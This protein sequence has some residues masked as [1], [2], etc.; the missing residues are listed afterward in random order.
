[1]AKSELLLA[2]NELLE[3]RHL[4]SEAVT[5]VLE[6]AL[7]AAY[8][9]EAGAPSSQNVE[10]EID[11]A[12]G[13][14]SVKAEKEV[15]LEV[16]NPATEISLEEAE[17][18]DPEVQ[19]GD[20]V[21]V[22]VT[23]ERLGRVAAQTARQVL[24]QRLREVE[25]ELQ[26]QYFSKLEG[27]I[28]NGIVQAVRPNGV[29][30]GLE[31]NT[32]ALL[33]RREQIPG[34]R[35]RVHDRVRALLLE[36]KPTG[37]G[38]QV[39]LSRAHKNFLRRLLED[40]V[41]EI[42]RGEVEIRAIAREAGRRSK[43]A[44]SA[45]APT[46]DPVGACVGL[47]GVRIQAIMR[48][49][50]GEKIDVIEWNPDPEVFIA[51]AL[52]PAQVTGVYLDHESRTAT[53]VVP[54]DQLSLAIGRQ[55]QNARLAAKLTGWR[56]D[57]KNVSEA[58]SEALYKLQNDPQY[59]PFAEAEAETIPV[60]EAILAKK[61]EGRLLAPEEYR[62]LSR[63]VDRVER[64]V[65]ARRAEE[66]SE[67][68]R[69]LAE[70][71]AQIPEAAFELPVDVLGLTPRITMLLTNA[72]YN[73]IGDLM[74]QMKLNPDEVL[75][76][77]GIGPKAMEQITETLALFEEAHPTEEPQ[78]EVEEPVAPAEGEPHLGEEEAVAEAE[79][80]APV[81]EAKAEAEA[82][83][84]VAAEVEE[85]VEEA[86][87][88]AEAASEAAEEAEE[89]EES[90]S[91]EDIFAQVEI[92]ADEVAVDEEAEEEELAADK[93]RKKKKKKKKKKPRQYVELAYGESEDDL[94]PV[95][96][97]KREDE[98]EEWDF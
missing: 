71:R 89:V 22:D 98:W 82:E 16:E 79:A 56:I 25:R 91:L 87:P 38:P 2:F 70:A 3:E 34:E 4:P 49:L 88:E 68:A 86:T 73:S 61:A 60:V 74:L 50:H 97:H 66:L 27:E 95:K 42:Y 21:M 52:S 1:M 12:D 59:A 96:R 76:L 75:A 13:H 14:F 17:Q 45:I 15:V 84:Q 67:E 81:E 51:K 94:I 72:G 57:I 5:S 31:K 8:R 28:V 64:G 47:R 92:P 37:K 65:I 63:F 53:V 32:E 33:P 90:A 35:F 18:I 40:E 29:T 36:V 54:E 7:A 24:Q 55:G 93:P 62:E 30:V 6:K 80:L 83:T 11:M 41:P 44:V 9:K 58:A 26:Y 48:E 43:V 46:I 69:R 78:A 10:V 39:I 85:A 77:D 20:V 23:P 19:L